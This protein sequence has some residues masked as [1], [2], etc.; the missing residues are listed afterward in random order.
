MSKILYPVGEVVMVRKDKSRTPY[1]VLEYCKGEKYPYRL[2]ACQDPFD[3]Q[4]SV[5]GMSKFSVKGLKRYSPKELRSADSV[6]VS[7]TQAKVTEA[8]PQV[9][10]APKKKCNCITREEVEAML[11]SA[12]N[13]VYHDLGMSVQNLD[14]KVM[15]LA[16]LTDHNFGT[17]VKKF[18][19]LNHDDD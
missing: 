7:P 13:D 15:R 8:S 5:N 17:V 10:V 11:M 2:K 19:T 9:A 16:E 6:D 4:V 14:G 12:L 3:D 1:Q 18:K